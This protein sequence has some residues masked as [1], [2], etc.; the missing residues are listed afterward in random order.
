MVKGKG[1]KIKEGKQGEL[2]LLKNQ[3]ARALADYDNFRKRVETEKL[4][5]EAEAESRAVLKLLPIL[6]MIEDAQGHLKDSG[7]AIVIDEFK[8]S[9]NDL[10][11][12]EI[13]VRSGDYF[14]PLIEEA[15]EIVTGSPEN[16][17]SEVVR[18]GWKIRNQP[19]I[20]R[21]A[22]VKVSGKV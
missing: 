10:G 6:D 22:R 20:I 16:M 12:E 18:S 14:D 19:Y 17:V 8:K 15:T 4:G 5:W 9:L 2:D 21:P 7:L 13:V 11:V 1:L 3:L